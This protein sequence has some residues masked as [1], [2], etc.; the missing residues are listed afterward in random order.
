MSLQLGR[1]YVVI[2]EGIPCVVI[3][4][5]TQRELSLLERIQ[6]LPVLIYEKEKTRVRFAHL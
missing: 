3:T 1:T 4:T 2:S 5:R 6:K